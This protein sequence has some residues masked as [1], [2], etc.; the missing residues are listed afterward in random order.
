[1]SGLIHITAKISEV[2][3]ISIE[4]KSN[5]PKVYSFAFALLILNIILTAQI[6]FFKAQEKSTFN[7]HKHSR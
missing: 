1:M 2:S 3:D 6:N 4:F 5:L 7:S